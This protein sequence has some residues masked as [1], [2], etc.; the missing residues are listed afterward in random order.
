MRPKVSIIVPVYNTE[1]YLDRCLT[2]LINQT[3]KDIQ[4]IVVNDGSTDDSLN[5]ISK[6]AEN[7]SRILIVNQVNQGSG[8]ARKVGI[9]YAEGEYVIVCD[10]D[11]WVEL[12]MYENLYEEATKSN[13]DLVSCDSVIEYPDRSCIVSSHLKSST[14][15]E[16][17]VE[18][19]SGSNN[20]SCNKM[21]KRS[22]IQ[23]NRINFQEG[24]NLGEDALFLY[25]LLPH[26]HLISSIS[27]PYYHYRRTLNSG[28]CTG[29]M[30]MNKALQLRSV[31]EWLS[32]NY[33]AKYKEYK[34]IQAVNVA[35]AMLRADDM[36]AKIFRKFL[37][38][39]IK[40]CAFTMK[41]SILKQ[42]LV[43]SAKLFRPVFIKKIFVLTYPY[44]YR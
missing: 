4:I 11:D 12:D 3:L 21:I 29:T 20:S 15:Q 13:V 7:D 19:L 9:N 18:V 1:M 37:S 35:F 34:H 30:N 28:S 38:D 31:F 27:K 33:D 16:L 39:Q 44:V 6:Y 26:I 14:Q 40:W 43:Y 36:D 8:T 17:I 25:K 23:D 41:A 10:S 24:I 22:I 32:L 2:S 5:I 42:I